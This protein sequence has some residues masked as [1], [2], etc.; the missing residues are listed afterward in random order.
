MV[1]KT[2]LLDFIYEN[3]KNLEGDWEPALERMNLYDDVSEIYL[4]QHKQISGTKVAKSMITNRE[5]NTIL[6]F[7]LLAYH[8][9][10]EYLDFQKDRFD[11]KV[12][13]ITKLAGPSALTNDLYTAT[14]Y[15]QDEQINKVIDWVINDQKDSRFKYYIAAKES[16]SQAFAQ[17]MSGTGSVKE[18]ADRARMLKEAKFNDADADLVYEILRTEFMKLDTVLEKEGKQKITSFDETT[19]FMSH[20]AFIRARDHK[21][22]VDQIES[23]G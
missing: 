23:M 8:N 1:S 2:K 11:N 16:A 17:A 18:G 13:I 6:A 12:K 9:R 14:V 15:C 22:M 20:E 10:S 3:L 4:L 19:N 21:T 7:I 5:A